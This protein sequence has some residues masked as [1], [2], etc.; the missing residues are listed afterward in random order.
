MFYEGGRV[1]AILEE[2][3]SRAVDVVVGLKD[4]GC[5]LWQFVVCCG[6]DEVHAES[7]VP[8]SPPSRCWSFLVE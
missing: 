1:K 7:C 5:Y 2:L 4:G 3:I 6:E 8:G